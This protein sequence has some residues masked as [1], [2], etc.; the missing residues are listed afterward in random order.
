VVVLLEG[1]VAGVLLEARVEG[2][3][4]GVLPR[5][6]LHVLPAAASPDRRHRRV[7]HQVLPGLGDLSLRGGQ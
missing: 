6:L 3:V 7:V 1:P 4:A 5:R 2:P